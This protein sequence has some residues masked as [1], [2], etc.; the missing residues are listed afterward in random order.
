MGYALPMDATPA[1][2]PE[3]DFDRE[4]VASAAAVAP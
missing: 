3:C 2:R 1:P 4:I